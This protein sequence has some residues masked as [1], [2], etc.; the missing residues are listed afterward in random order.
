MTEEACC[1][2][3]FWITRE[4][5]NGLH[6]NC[7]RFPPVLD[8]LQV[9]FARDNGY[10]DTDFAKDCIL[11]WAQPKTSH[12]EWCGEFVLRHGVMS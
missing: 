2:C 7:K 10:S 4:D 3:K 1:K 12:E 8:V 11:W 9:E 6:G 5:E